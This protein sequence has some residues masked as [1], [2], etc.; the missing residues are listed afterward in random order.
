MDP[1][2]QLLQVLRGVDRNA[3]D[4]VR[5]AMG[6]PQYYPE[7]QQVQTPQFAPPPDPVMNPD[8][9]SR[10]EPL[11]VQKAMQGQ[12]EMNA[13][14]ELIKALDQQASQMKLDDFD[15]R[16]KPQFAPQGRFAGTT[17][18]DLAAALAREPKTGMYEG[19]TSDEVAEAL[20]KPKQDYQIQRGDTLSKLAGK[21]GT[22]VEELARMNGIADPNMIYA[23]QTLRI[24]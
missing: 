8:K 15:R 4:P 11:E 24:A 3:L 23:G 9:T 17:S 16:N 5:G 21:F 2:E 6:L 10:Y 20:P 1:Y 14:Y 7:P 12:Q 22:T 19:T 18:D 13:R